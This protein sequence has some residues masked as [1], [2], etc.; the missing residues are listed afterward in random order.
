MGIIMAPIGKRTNFVC[1]FYILI[2]KRYH[3]IDMINYQGFW[4]P[5]VKAPSK[6]FTK[7]DKSNVIQWCMN[8]D[9]LVTHKAD[10]DDQNKGKDKQ[11]EIDH[12]DFCK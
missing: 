7:N 6:Y 11:K 3:K 10:G 12:D 1:K 4:G 9:L 2:N 8:L 5:K